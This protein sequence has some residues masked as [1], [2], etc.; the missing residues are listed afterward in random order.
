[1]NIQLR[2]VVNIGSVYKTDDEQGLAH[3]VEHLAFRGTKLFD[4][5]EV[6]LNMCDR[7]PK[8]NQNFSTCSRCVLTC[9]TGPAK[10]KNLFDTFEACLDMCDRTRT[11]V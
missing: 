10:K 8:K 11:Q 1:M 4:T 5:F 6:C 2:L 9:V 3:M 7:T